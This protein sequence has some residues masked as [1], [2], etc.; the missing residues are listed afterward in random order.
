[1][2][3]KR[4]INELFKDKLKTS[5]SPEL[6][7]RIDSLIARADKKQTQT[8]NTWRLIMKNRITKFAA[9]AVI[10]IAVTLSITLFDKTATPAWAIEDTI[11]AL[12]NV[13]SIKISG[14]APNFSLGEFG[15]QL[16]G[17]FVIWAKPDENG[18]G[19]KELRFE[20]S[21]WVIAVDASE[22]TYFYDS[23]QNCVVVKDFNNFHMNPWLGSNF[24]HTVK[25]FAENWKVSYGKDEETDRESIFATCIYTPEVKSWWIQFDAETRLPVR[26][27]Q[28]KNMT[29][30]GAP[31]FFAENIEYNPPLPEGI[32][33]F[34]IPE[35]AKVIHK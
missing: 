26:F 7:R 28:W 16:D 30:E 35:G 29:F 21:N 2:R 27:K 14:P 4:K 1:M 19:S 6:D 32:F 5:A 8:S 3:E 11:E 31:E 17:D 34:E 9:A 20:G 33:E 22:K 10:I 24:F 18:L 13:Y 12:E 25:R 23:E 15:R